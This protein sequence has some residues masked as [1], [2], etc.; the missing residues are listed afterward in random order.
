MSELVLLTRR[1]KA[2]V[3]RH[4]VR[5]T[6]WGNGKKFPVTSQGNKTIENDWKCF[7]ITDC[8]EKLDSKNS[9]LTVSSSSFF[10][11]NWE[12]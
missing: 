7:D 4:Q 6:T 2:V 3:L 8:K 12:E 1:R 10:E 11:K 5:S 9:F